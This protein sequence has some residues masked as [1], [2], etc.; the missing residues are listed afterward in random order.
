LAYAGR[1]DEAK[2]NFE[3]VAKTKAVPISDLSSLFCRAM[4]GDRRRVQEL[5]T[6]NT[7]LQEAAKTDEWFPN[8]I[9]ACLTHVGN[10][11]GAL[12]WLERAIAWGFSNHRFLSEHSRFLAPLRGDPRFEALMERARE[13]ERAFQ[14]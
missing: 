4:E 6:E 5:L 2:I 7:R 3:Q 13:K 8:F 10:N 12:E 11:D 9:A 1:L 14:V